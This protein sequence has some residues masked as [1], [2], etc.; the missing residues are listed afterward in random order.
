MNEIKNPVPTIMIAAPIGLTLCGALFIMANIAYFSVGTPH[1]IANS[2]VTVAS[3][4]MG[5]VFGS[6]ARKAVR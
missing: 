4:F 2:G 6:A 5:K 1:E 3:F